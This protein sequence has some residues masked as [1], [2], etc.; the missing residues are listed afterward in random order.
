ILLLA[1]SSR[2]RRFER[3]HAPRQR[4]AVSDL[5]GMSFG[6]PNNGLSLSWRYASVSSTGLAGVAHTDR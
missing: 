3:G 6:A 2:M 4:L 5:R 1:F